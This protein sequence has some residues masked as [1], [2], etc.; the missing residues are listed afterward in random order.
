MKP[1]TKPHAI[2]NMGK[3]A[4]S[5]YVAS[6]ENALKL[7]NEAMCDFPAV[8]ALADELAEKRGPDAPA[9]VS[10][11]WLPDA[12][13]EVLDNLP[14]AELRYL[15]SRLHGQPGS[16]AD[17][18]PVV[19]LD[20]AWQQELVMFMFEHK[21]GSSAKSLAVEQQQLAWKKLSFLEPARARLPNGIR[22]LDEY[23]LEGANELIILRANRWKDT[24]LEERVIGRYVGF[25]NNWTAGRW[26]LLP[27]EQ[28]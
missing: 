15:R 14:G 6:I 5:L 19:T 18:R 3:H 27:I 1:M 21:L 20:L 12:L 4:T 17:T 22:I 2:L 23:V 16:D 8:T 24:A 9:L 13:Q 7:V 28:A 11:Q 26:D 25:L 10:T